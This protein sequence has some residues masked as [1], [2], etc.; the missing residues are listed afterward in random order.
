M[1]TGSVP[2]RA[3]ASW[4]AA[5]SVHSG[6]PFTVNP[7]LQEPLPTLL[8]ASL[9]A[10]F[11]VKTMPPRLVLGGGG[12]RSAVL[13]RRASG[14]QSLASS[15]ARAWRR[16]SKAARSSAVGSGLPVSGSRARSGWAAAAGWRSVSRSCSSASALGARPCGASGRAARRLSRRAAWRAS[17]AASAAFSAC[18]AAR[19]WGGRA[20]LRGGGERGEKREGEEQVRAC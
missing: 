17:S 18:A 1:V 16:C 19:C 20:L 6:L 13:R 9:S 5:R 10:E 4:R 15:A 2:A 7:V 8:S 12:V 11:T 3:L 14:R